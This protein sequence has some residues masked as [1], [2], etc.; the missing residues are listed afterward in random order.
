MA[1]ARAVRRSTVMEPIRP[2]IEPDDMTLPLTE[3][4][5]AAQTPPEVRELLPTAAIPLATDARASVVSSLG[6]VPAATFLGAVALA[7]IS[8]VLAH[9]GELLASDAVTAA[10]VLCGVVGIV[11]LARSR[12]R[13]RLA[14]ARLRALAAR[15]A[16]QVSMLSH[17]IRTPLAVI[18]G[19]AELLAEQAPGPLLPR[20]EIFV[21][22]IVD[23]ASRMQTLAEQLLMQAR[24]ESGAFEI[25]RARVDLRAL[26]RDVV[27]ELGPVAGVPIVLQTPGAPVSAWVDPQLIRQV[28]N[29]LIMN[30]ARS[31]P[32]T[33]AIE[34]RVTAG[35]DHVLV[36]VSDGGSGMT[37]AQ[38]DRLFRRFQSGRPLGNGTGIGLFISQ[39]L[40]QLHGGR[41]FVDTITGKGT[42]MLFTLPLGGRHE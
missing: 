18:Q 37:D 8:V 31:D 10:A 36:A 13:D 27:A 40:V 6:L 1:P 2:P 35:E 34:V 4:G 9:G 39:Q 19:S 15:R 22:R 28:M 32:G 33:S 41:I 20:Q 11:V 7:V 17:E 3:I 16:D 30:A 21:Q 26:M 29:N 42:T 38:R 5:A 25:Q 12:G 24:L 23:N 14:N